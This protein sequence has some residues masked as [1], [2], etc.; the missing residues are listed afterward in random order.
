MVYSMKRHAHMVDDPLRATPLLKAIAKVVKKGNVV[1]D[2]GTG[3]GILAIAAAKS[4][5][6]HVYAIDCDKEALKIAQKNARKEG[7]E[8]KITFLNDLSFNVKLPKKTDVI[9]C[10]TVGSF[11]F[12]ENILLT[13]A[14]AKKRFLKRGG[15]II[16]AA[17][18]LFGAPCFELPKIQHPQEIALIDKSK[19]A[20]RPIVI[21]SVCF[22]LRFSKSI[23]VKRSFRCEKSGTIKSI[24]VWPKALWNISEI[25][26]ASPFNKPTHWKQGILE[27]EPRKV[28]RNEKV[29][30]EIIIQPDEHA[31]LTRTERLWRWN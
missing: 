24:A 29:S 6:K 8:N 21:S 14:D 22:G 26:D 25:T 17:L 10:E 23:H 12:D 18:E 16:P 19:L 20:S 28:K 1:A 15:K 31:P 7:V 9:I 30:I 4:G 2:I 5:A 27:I 13:L 3:T 11:A